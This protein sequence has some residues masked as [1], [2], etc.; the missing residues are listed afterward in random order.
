MKNKNN[1]KQEA[2]KRTFCS[3][4]LCKICGVKSGREG[5]LKRA[6]IGLV[7]S[8]GEEIKVIEAG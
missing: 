6:I 2:I 5:V 8:G 3:C 1:I 7:K 4:R